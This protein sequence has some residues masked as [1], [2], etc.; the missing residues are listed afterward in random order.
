M[1]DTTWN[2]ERTLEMPAAESEIHTAKWEELKQAHD[3]DILAGKAG[4]HSLFV[5]EVVEMKLRATNTMNKA[6]RQKQRIPGRRSNS[7]SAAGAAQIVEHCEQK[8]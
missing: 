8:L 5:K 3:A 4:L 1:N 6:V 7:S 2:K